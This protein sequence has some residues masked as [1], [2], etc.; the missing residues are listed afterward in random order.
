MVT[1][2][3]VTGRSTRRLEV[4]RHPDGTPVVGQWEPIL[5]VAEWEAVQA[6]LVVRSAGRA[7]RPQNHNVWRHLLSGLVRCGECG[8]PMRGMSTGSRNRNGLPAFVYSCQSQALGGCGRV[9]RH[10]PKTDAAIVGAVLAKLELE[11]AG[12]QVEP[13]EWTG[14][15]ELDAVS[16]RITDLTAAWKAGQVSSARYFAMLPEL[17]ADQRHLVADR[18]A[19]RA[20]AEV[21]RTRPAAVRAEWEDY[22]L[23]RRRQIIDDTL[24]AIIVHKAPRRGAPFDPDLLEPI[25]RTD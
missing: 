6:A 11:L 24:A 1:T 21:V 12:A 9:S 5:T 8:K 4:V 14:S 18:G 17:E 10:G 13:G 16:A 19:H 20:A 2:D 22:P 25:W 15:G 3:P 23:T 7:G